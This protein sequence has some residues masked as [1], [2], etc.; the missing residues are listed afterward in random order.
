M[1]NELMH[2]VQRA[3]KERAAPAP[4]MRQVPQL[5]R[6]EMWCSKKDRGFIVVLVPDGHG[7][8]RMIRNEPMP[9]AV[10]GDGGPARSPEQLGSFRIDA[11]QWRC[12]LC[13]TPGSFWMCTS[14]GCGKPFHCRGSVG[15]DF[16]YCRCHKLEQRA[17]VDVDTFDVAAERSGGG[18]ASTPGVSSLS[19]ARANPALP[20][21]PTARLP[22]RK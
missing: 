16:Y 1:S 17:F 18:A 22:Y 4:P 12:P 8:L 20:S 15:G 2:R 7:G 14:L 13:D 19:G 6:M 11:R 5:L 3:L 9:S 10:A 21:P